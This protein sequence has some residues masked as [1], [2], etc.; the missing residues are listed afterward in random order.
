MPKWESYIHTHTHTDTYIHTYT[1][2]VLES[3]SIE[4]FKASR[5]FINRTP[6]HK[7]TSYGSFL[8]SLFRENK[9]EMNYHVGV[10]KAAVYNIYVLF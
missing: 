5:Q 3:G 2:Q 8:V 7:I 9:T 6:R 10:G 4:Q 1:K